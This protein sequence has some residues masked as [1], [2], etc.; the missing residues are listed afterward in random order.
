ME[1]VCIFTDEYMP[2]MHLFLKLFLMHA[3]QNVCMFPIGLKT[4]DGKHEY[5]GRL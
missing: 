3:F 5:K 2:F 1:F 4:F